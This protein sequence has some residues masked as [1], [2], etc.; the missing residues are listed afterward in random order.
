MDGAP[1]DGQD[2]TGGST[3]ERDGATLSFVAQ[4]PFIMNETLRENVLFGRAC[5]SADERARYARALAAA[6]LSRD[7]EQLPAGDLTEIGERDGKSAFVQLIE[8]VH[9]IDGLERIRF[10]SPHPKGYGDGQ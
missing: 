6:Q 2:A 10:T 3:V 9:G 1:D 5:A 8:A 4:T 7:L